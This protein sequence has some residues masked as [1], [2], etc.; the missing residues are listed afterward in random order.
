MIMQTKWAKAGWRIAIGI[1]VLSMCCPDCLGGPN[2]VLPRIDI[3]APGLENALDHLA[4]SLWH[5]RAALGTW[6]ILF[7]TKEQAWF[8]FVQRH[9]ADPLRP[10]GL[11][12]L[13]VDMDFPNPRYSKEISVSG[14]NMTLE[15]VLDSIAEQQGACVWWVNHDNNTVHFVDEELFDDPE[16]PLARNLDVSSLENETLQG[17]A[18]RLLGPGV[19]VQSWR[20]P[21]LVLDTPVSSLSVKNRKGREVFAESLGMFG[22]PETRIAHVMARECPKILPSVTGPGIWQ[23]LMLRCH[24]A[25]PKITLAAAKELSDRAKPKKK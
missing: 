13:R 9:G 14:N 3:E 8:D 16:W 2:V 20:D 5:Q 10:P 1:G 6:C 25:L 7:E 24:S 17:L 19:R 18:R 4:V 23:Y 22:K 15:N 21:T 12:T 11:A